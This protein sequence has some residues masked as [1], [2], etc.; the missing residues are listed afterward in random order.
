MAAL[1]E[2]NL[3]RLADLDGGAIQAALKRQL[4]LA[5]A[6]LENRPTVTSARTVTLK[7]ALAP[8]TDDTGN[9]DAVTTDFEINSSIPKLASRAFRMDARR[10]SRSGRTEHVLMFAPDSPRDPK[11][12]T[13]PF[14]QDGDPADA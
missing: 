5:L 13:V 11:A 9:L 6:D 2:F 7:I 8:E 14:P 3:D 1:Q 4:S 12:N 10:V